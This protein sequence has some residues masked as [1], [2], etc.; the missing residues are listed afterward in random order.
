MEGMSHCTEHSAVQ[1]CSLHHAQ[2]THFMC[3]QPADL[4]STDKRLVLPCPR[5]C[6]AA[7]DTVS[8]CPLP[9][10][11]CHMHAPCRLTPAKPT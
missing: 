3:R 11:G 6:A 2:P 7:T 9:L 8:S 10:P 1:C 5:E 4:P